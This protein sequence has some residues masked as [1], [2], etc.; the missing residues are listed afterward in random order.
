MKTDRPM[1]ASSENLTVDM[2]DQITYPKLVS[3]KEDGIRCRLMCRKEFSPTSTSPISRSGKLIPNIHV[4]DWAN[5]HGIAGLDGE[6]I[7]PGAD[8]HTIQSKVMT[9]YTPPFPFI[10]R[11]FDDYAYPGMTTLQRL[12][13]AENK[14]KR[15]APP[16][17][18]MIKQTM[19]YDAKR[20][21]NLFNS[22]TG[23]GKEGLII[24]NPSAPYKEGRCTF[25]SEWSMK[26]KAFEDAEAQ[27]IGFEEEM[28]NQNGKT[29]N[30]LGY[31]KRSTHK[32]NK[33][34]KG[35]L[36]AFIVTD[37]NGPEFSVGSGMTH[38]QKLAFWQNR[39]RLIGM[40]ICY[41]HQPHGRIKGGAPRTPIFRGIRLD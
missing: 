8:F 36:G 37:S 7:I 32:A 15:Y 13:S 1:L 22:V 2:L 34:G 19:I 16:Q 23:R 21:Y 30:E 12:Q 9:R 6:I 18:E 40:S 4:Q 17:V 26:M 31:S 41:K 3:T 24:R 10:F 39:V 20:L 35:I 29:T 38:E 28:E 33:K 14:I 25:L 5:E 27:I 11:V